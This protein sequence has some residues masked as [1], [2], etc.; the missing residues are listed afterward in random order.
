[1]ADKKV[2]DL[3][4]E[5]LRARPDLLAAEAQIKMA[6]A[7]IEVNRATGMPTLNLS[8]GSTYSVDSVLSNS[9]NDGVGVALTIPLFSG[10]RPTYLVR[11]AEAQK[12]LHIADRDRIINQISLDVWKAY[13]TLKTNTESLQSAQ[14]LVRSAEQSERM[15]VGRYKAGLGTMIDV[16]TAQ[17]ILVSARQQLISTRFNLIASRFT[18]AQTIGQ[19]DIA[20]AEVIRE[21][22]SER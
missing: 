7:Q 1:M 4:A 17:N 6:E 14:D 10:Y 13:Q 2:A 18:L 16:L 21:T 8:A 3:I 12:A 20:H 22:F 9:R 19:L 15:T 11:S 5:A